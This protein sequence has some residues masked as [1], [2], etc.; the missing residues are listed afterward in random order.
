M[1]LSVL[2]VLFFFYL[3]YLTSSKFCIM[4]PD[5]CVCLLRG[6]SWFTHTDPE[7]PQIDQNKQ[8]WPE[9]WLTLFFLSNWRR[10]LN[11]RTVPFEQH[12]FPSLHSEEEPK[13][14]RLVCLA[15]FCVVSALVKLFFPGF[16]ILQNL[17]AEG[18]RN[19]STCVRKCLIFCLLFILI[20]FLNFAPVSIF[21]A[22]FLTKAINK[23]LRNFIAVPFHIYMLV[24]LN[25]YWGPSFFLNPKWKKS[26]Q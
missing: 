6:F 12:S 5:L 2:F 20:L 19:Y 3:T 9:K 7:Q 21:E 1:L 15:L 23:D 26:T 14:E 10:I 4:W 24:I 17:P 22:F 18:D 25:Y 11:K 13:M 8:T 16:N